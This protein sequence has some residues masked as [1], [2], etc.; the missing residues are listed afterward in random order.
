[1]MEIVYFEN[2]VPHGT[3]FDY[4]D[5]G[6]LRVIGVYERGMKSGI[7]HHYNW[8]GELKE[9][10]VVDYTDFEGEIA[11]FISCSDEVVGDYNVICFGK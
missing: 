2:G 3:Y 7:W 10:D 11:E 9:D 8:A 5:E 4:D 6:T 1:M